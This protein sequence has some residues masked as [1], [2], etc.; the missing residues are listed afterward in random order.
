[1]NRLE[2][3]YKID[4]RALAIVQKYGSTRKAIEH[5]TL[6]LEEYHS[7]WGQYSCDCLGQGIQCSQLLI[8]HLTYSEKHEVPDGH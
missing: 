6:Q 8:E 3:S 7:L 2:K 1:M 4:T 5:L